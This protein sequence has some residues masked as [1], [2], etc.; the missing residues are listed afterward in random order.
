M[1]IPFKARAAHL[2]LRAGAAFALAYPAVNAWGDPNSWVGYFPP[3]VLAWGAA[4]GLSNIVI[5]HIFGAVELLLA[6][7]LLSG[8]R[9]FWPAAISTILL[10]AIVICNFSQMQIVFR[11]LSVAAMTLALAI[12]HMPRT[13][14]GLPAEAKELQ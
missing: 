13:R 10:V 12:T 2:L 14:Q 3:F 4:V 11:D 8:W 9:I 6:L 5:L 1:G 7:W